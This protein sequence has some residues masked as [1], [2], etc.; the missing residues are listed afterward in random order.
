MAPYQEVAATVRTRQNSVYVVEGRSQRR[1]P[2]PD[3]AGDERKDACVEQ[4]QR[5]LSAEGS[6]V[7]RRQHEEGK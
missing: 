5:Q 1:L 4:E 2:I 3:F 7:N 6:D